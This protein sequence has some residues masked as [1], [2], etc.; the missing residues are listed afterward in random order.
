MANGYSSY[1]ATLRNASE[2]SRNV[3][4]SLPEMA[5]ISASFLSA[6]R[7]TVILRKLIRGDRSYFFVA[8][9]NGGQNAYRTS[10]IESR[11]RVH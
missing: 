11:I 8:Q 6:E 7:R 1:I 2:I 3:N 5:Q 4:Q 10:I 9:S